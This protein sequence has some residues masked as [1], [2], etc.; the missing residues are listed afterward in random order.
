MQ[1]HIVTGK[2]P[3]PFMSGSFEPGQSDHYIENLNDPH[4][5]T[6]ALCERHYYRSEGAACYRLA[7]KLMKN[8]NGSIRISAMLMTGFGALCMGD[9][10]KA[11]KIIQSMRNA[12]KERSDSGY[13]YTDE[14]KQLV[15]FINNLS[16]ILLHLEGVAI[17]PLA[18]HK[19]PMGIRLIALYAFAHQQYLNGAYG[20]AIGIAK[21]ALELKD[22]T[23]PV[24]ETYLHLVLAMSYINQKDSDKANAH[25][26]SAWNMAKWE[27]FYQPFAEH[28]GLLGGMV[29]IHLKKDE[30]E[31]FI[32]ITEQVYRFA[33][34][35]RGIHNPHNQASVTDML[36][37]TE[38]TIAMLASKGWS[39]EQIAG[40]LGVSINTVKDNVKKI[41][42]KLKI[43]GRKELFH[44]MLK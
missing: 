5:T 43:G 13:E 15:A 9:S 31:A 20:E 38:F 8:E 12:Y 24:G 10:K 3:L 25:F 2:H 32:A 30:P 41:Y 18:L 28:H 11:A 42:K 6:L 26:L 29:E 33:G 44:Y 1:E 35:W 22:G 21:T 37:T 34:A 7:K 39:N 23:Y 36:T 4:T 14:E 17:L 16:I 40:H 27:G 19:L